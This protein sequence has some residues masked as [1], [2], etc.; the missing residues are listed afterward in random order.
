MQNS[1]K[2]CQNQNQDLVCVCLPIAIRL[3]ICTT[4]QKIFRAHRS[5]L[6]ENFMQANQNM[7]STWPP[8]FGESIPLY[9]LLIMITWLL[10]TSQASRLITVLIRFALSYYGRY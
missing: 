7:V 8:T 5:S 9:T 6:D 10:I 3:N 2:C 1:Y 4:F